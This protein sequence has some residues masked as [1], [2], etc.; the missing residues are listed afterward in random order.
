MLIINNLITPKS[1]KNIAVTSPRIEGPKPQEYCIP[2]FSYVLQRIEGITNDISLDLNM[3]LYPKVKPR[4]LENWHNNHTMGEVPVF[5]STYGCKCFNG[6]FKQKM[7]NLMGRLV[8]V[9]TYL[10]GLMIICNC[11]F[12]DHLSKLTTALRMLRR[13]GLKVN[14]EKIVFFVP[15]I[16][17]RW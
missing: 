3:S 5:T 2:K 17:Y 12:E 10:D 16:E 4:C 6:F 15:K 9:C 7:A 13:E 1:Q 8:F 11:T 14:V